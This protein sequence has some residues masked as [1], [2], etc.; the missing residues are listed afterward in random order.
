VSLDLV[1]YGA[2]A[3][4]I[5]L[6]RVL[7][8]PGPWVGRATLAT[9]FALVGALGL[10]LSALPTSSFLSA[11]PLALLFAGVILAATV[12]VEQL[13][14][15]ERPRPP[16]PPGVPPPGSYWRF[17]LPPALLVALGAGLALGHLVHWPG[18]TILTDALYVLLFL[19]G[20]DL[21]LRLAAMRTIA[22]PLTAAVAGALVGG[23]VMAALFGVPLRPAL[24]TSFAF[25]WYSL[26]GPLV[27]QSA[28]PTAGL[29]AFLTNFLRENATMVSAPLVGRRLRGEGLT[30]MGGATALDT[31]LYFIT[32]YG[33]PDAGTLALS[34][35]LILT[36]AAGVI[37]P[38]LLGL[39][40]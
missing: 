21:R 36:L 37:V 28:G 39:G 19:V 27:A 24:A 16:P 26:A 20:F 7:P 33:D 18:G 34:T 5:G 29:V 14:V 31:T 4:G 15:R 38:G 8:H 32:R 22:V 1:L 40:G 9:I 23:L 10:V 12:L 2:L 30:A 35:G 11:I 25:G 6:G 13:W 17:L 3:A